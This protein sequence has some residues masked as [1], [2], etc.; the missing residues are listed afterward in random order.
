MDLLGNCFSFFTGDNL[1]IKY[2]KP[3]TR[4]KIMMEMIRMDITVFLNDLQY[5][6]RVVKGKSL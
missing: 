2:P 3:T 1:N 4:C 6:F 5:K